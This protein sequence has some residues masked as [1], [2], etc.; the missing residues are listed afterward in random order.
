MH[1]LK[2]KIERRQSIILPTPPTPVMELEIE[3]MSIH[4]SEEG[5]SPTTLKRKRKA[6]FNPQLLPTERIDDSPPAKPK[7]KSM[8]Y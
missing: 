8:T 1:G 6:R 2:I 5:L 7:M 3:K 4:E